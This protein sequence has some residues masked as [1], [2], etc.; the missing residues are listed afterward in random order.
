MFWSSVPCTRSPESAG[1]F[2]RGDNTGGRGRVHPPP[3]IRCQSPPTGPEHSGASFCG[4]CTRWQVVH[5]QMGSLSGLQFTQCGVFVASCC[6]SSKKASTQRGVAGPVF[7]GS[8]KQRVVNIVTDGWLATA[9]P[10]GRINTGAEQ[11][12][13]LRQPP[14][15]P[16]CLRCSSGSRSSRWAFPCSGTS[17]RLPR[18]CGGS[19]Q[20]AVAAAANPLTLRR[21]VC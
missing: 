3:T 8:K 9:G 5:I 2:F 1:Q 16:F 17:V 11:F 12:Y 6:G 14:S 21:P 19:L 7:L 20:P 13:L 18:L 10:P 15:T 4:Q